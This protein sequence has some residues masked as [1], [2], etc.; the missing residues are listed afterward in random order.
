M[1]EPRGA[2]SFLLVVRVD[3]LEIL[4]KT[5]AF[6]NSGDRKF[7]ESEPNSR[8]HMPFRMLE[9]AW[10]RMKNPAIAWNLIAYT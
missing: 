2:F 4:Q 5:Q 8:A 10:K 1:R 9:S 6:N 7:G 3:K